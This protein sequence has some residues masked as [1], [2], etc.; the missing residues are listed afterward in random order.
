M[1]RDA[2]ITG[3][4]D[5]VAWQKAMTLVTDIYRL[6]ERLP[7]HERFGLTS[8]LRRAA[9]SVPSNVAEGHGRV[10]K[11]DYQ[12]FVDIARGST[13]E[14]ETQLLVAVNLGFLTESHVDA[15]MT[16]LDELQRILKGLWRSLN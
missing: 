1:N 4:K 8:Q 5:L 16:L 7:D 15:T 3:F 11:K 13:N 2:N 10:Q 14:I 6:T 9:V 12:R